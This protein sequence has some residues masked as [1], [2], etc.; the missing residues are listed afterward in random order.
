MGP[1][2]QDKFDFVVSAWPGRVSVFA[3]QPVPGNRKAETVNSQTVVHSF[4]FTV[5][6]SRFT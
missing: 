1:E 5:S 4:R 2:Y 3:L 6:G